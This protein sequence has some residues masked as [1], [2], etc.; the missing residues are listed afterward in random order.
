MSFFNNYFC[1]LV[2]WYVDDV[3]TGHLQGTGQVKLLIFFSRH[4]VSYRITHLG[5]KQKHDNLFYRVSLLPREIVENFQ[6]VWCSAVTISWVKWRS[7]ST[8]GRAWTGDFSR[9]CPNMAQGSS[10]ELFSQ[11]FHKC[12]SFIQQLSIE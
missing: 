4:F 5:T 8:Q 3:N 9:H 6:M 12:H 7:T 2:K 1:P 11:L 10:L